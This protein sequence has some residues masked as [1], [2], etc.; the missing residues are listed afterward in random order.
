MA[1]ENLTVL[2]VQEF[3]CPQDQAQAFLWDTKSPGLALR[4]T[5]SGAKTFIFQSKIRGLGT[6]PRIAIGSPDTWKLPDARE[7]ARLYKLMTDKGQDPRE[8]QAAERKA[9]AAASAEQARIATRESIT[10]GDVWPTY[11][12]DRKPLWSEGHYNNHV[13]LSAEGGKEKKRGKGLTVKGPLYA[14]MDVRLTDLTSD[15]IAE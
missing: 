9:N 12:A 10:L 2:R 7:Q 8:V 14:L 15:R 4:V 6:D 3:T 1:K 13:N 5:R 11:L